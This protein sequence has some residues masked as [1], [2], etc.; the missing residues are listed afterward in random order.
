MYPYRIHGNPQPQVKF[1]HDNIAMYMQMFKE[2][3]ICNYHWGRRGEGEENRWDNK[4][5]QERKRQQNRSGGAEWQ[6][7]SRMKGDEQRC[8]SQYHSITLA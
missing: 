3:K 7:R 8:K 6:K 1:K 4:S 2:G 5:R